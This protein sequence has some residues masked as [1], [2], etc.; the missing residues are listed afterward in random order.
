MKKQFSDDELEVFEEK[1]IELMEQFKDN[2]LKTEEVQ[3]FHAIKLQILMDR[4]LESKQRARSQIIKLENLQKGIVDKYGGDFSRVEQRDQDSITQIGEQISS[5]AIAEQSASTEY[6][7]LQKEH[8]S[9]LEKLK[10]SR[11]QRIEKVENSKISFT[12]LVKRLMD[13]DFQEAES[14]TIELF[15]KASDKELTRLAEPHKYI[16]G[17][18]DLPVL[19]AETI[20]MLD[21]VEKKEQEEKDKKEKDEG[22]E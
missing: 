21:K 19:N 14:R 18:F 16:D 17:S 7:N 1:Y 6:I 22:K 9:L 12:G 8:N 11:F 20:D 3:L 4:N 15:K 2:V 5:F 13:R 10:A